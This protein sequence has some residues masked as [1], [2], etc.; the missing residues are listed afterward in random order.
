MGSILAAGDHRFPG[1]L[2]GATIRARG[3][4]GAAEAV[5]GHR[6]ARGQ[7]SQAFQTSG[8]ASSHF[9]A[10]SSLLILLSAMSV[11]TW[12]W[13]SLVHLKFLISVNAGLPLFANLV[14]ATLFR[15]YGG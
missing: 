3:W 9:F 6:W 11:A 1:L 14:E 8:W 13:S 15:L 2:Q 7:G 5:P 10:A 4:P 12:F